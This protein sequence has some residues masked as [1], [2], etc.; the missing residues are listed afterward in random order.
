MTD[1]ESMRGKVVEDVESARVEWDEDRLADVLG[2]IAIAADQDLAEVA[3]GRTS[4]ELVSAVEAWA[5]VAS[6]AV[7]RF[8]FEGP[9][10]ILRRGG[11]SESVASRLQE[12]LK[13]FSKHLKS[14]LRDTGASSFSVAIGFPWGVSVGLTWS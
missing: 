2:D 14:A 6:Y 1:F 9:E 10:S 11:W 7:A 4:D 5:S 12:A 3:T 13:T 8:Y